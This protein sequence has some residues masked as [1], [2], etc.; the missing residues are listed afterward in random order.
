MTSTA[1][2]VSYEADVRDFAASFPTPNV[3]RGVALAEAGTITW[4]Q[5]HEVCRGAL[6]QG[7]ATV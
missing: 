1:T 2:I 4:A 3:L 6:A 5:L 7:L